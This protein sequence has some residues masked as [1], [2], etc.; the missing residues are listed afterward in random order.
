M[1][2]PSLPVL[3][4]S[5]LRM[6]ASFRLSTLSYVKEEVENERRPGVEPVE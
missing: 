3:S 5:T 1:I 2:S 6:Y 4:Q